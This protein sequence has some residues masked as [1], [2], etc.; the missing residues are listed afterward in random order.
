MT[1]VHGAGDVN[2]YLESVNATITILLAAALAFLSVYI[3]EQKRQRGLTWL[4]C[5]LGPPPGMALA[6]PMWTIKLGL[7][8]TRG[9]IWTLRE[10]SDLDGPIGWELYPL[11]IGT[12]ISAVGALWLVGVLGR[13]RY[14]DWPWVAA[15][16]AA[17]A[18]V[19]LRAIKLVS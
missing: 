2:F 12:A 8:M 18:Y 3:V 17:L 16:C 14:G 19:A 9:A 13:A 4:A 7:V 15:G 1:T 5:W 11:L 6:M 10:F